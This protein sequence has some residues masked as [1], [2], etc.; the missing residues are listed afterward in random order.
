MRILLTNDDGIHALGLCALY[1]ALRESHEVYVVAPD[2]E[3]SAVGHA[4]T[5]VD[6]LRVR[7][8]RR[9]D[10][11]GWAINGTPADCVKL[12]VAELVRGPI[13]M[14]VSGINQGPNVGINILYS[15]TV[16]AATEASMMGLRSLAVS[17]DKYKDPDFCFAASF[18]SQLLLWLR[19]IGLP[20]GISVNVNIPALPPNRIKGV[21]VVPQGQ[22]SF[23]EKFDK[24]IDPRGN[25]YYWQASQVL[26]CKEEG[27]D[28]EALKAGYI[29]ITPIH[30]DLTSYEVMSML[31][32]PDF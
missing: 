21:K 11:M 28:T 3:K 19:D 32:P 22:S 10:F 24:R 29:T 23:V 18:T 9:G 30:Y 31:N 17:L 1:E 27:V 14:V 13:D 4:I 2:S 6:P 5:L 12:G 7:E 25:T 20:K 8:I 26:A 15:G 16:S